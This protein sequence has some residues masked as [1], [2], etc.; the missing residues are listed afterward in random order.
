MAASTCWQRAPGYD[1]IVVEVDIVAG[2]INTVPDIELHWHIGDG[3]DEDDE[4]EPDPIIKDT[5]P[6]QPVR[7]PVL[8]IREYFWPE[9]WATVSAQILRKN[10]Q[11]VV[12]PRVKQQGKPER[13]A[14]TTSEFTPTACQGGDPCAA[15]RRSVA[16]A[17]RTHS[18]IL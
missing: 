7:I 4:A 9:G 18:A 14:K 6:P 16:G 10:N 2:D 3:L 13:V 17:R 12:V 8:E 11:S 1:A 5:R 15:L